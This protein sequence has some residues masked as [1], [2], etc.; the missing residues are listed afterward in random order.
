MNKIIERAKIIEDKA[1]P[2]NI[3]YPPRLWRR[4]VRAAAGATIKEGKTITTSEWV[5][6]ACRAAL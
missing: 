2:H 3:K 6:R 4:I 1:V 5:R